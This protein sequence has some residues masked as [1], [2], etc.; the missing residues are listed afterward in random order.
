MSVA[1]VPLEFRKD[2]TGDGSVKITSMKVE[3]LDADKVLRSMSCLKI[4][5]HYR[6]AEVLRF[7]KFEVGIYDYTRD[8][9][10]YLLDSD[11]AG[12]LPEELPAEG[13]VTCVTDPFNLTAGRCSTYVSIYKCGALADCVAPAMTFDVAAAD[14]HG[15]GK[16]ASRE[17]FVGLLKHAWAEAPDESRHESARSDALRVQLATGIKHASN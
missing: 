4:T 7:P 2:R 13:C 14:I 6:S 17:W 11:A 1:Q 15:S 8:S 9:G 12:S 10:V 5:V 16:Q 3:S